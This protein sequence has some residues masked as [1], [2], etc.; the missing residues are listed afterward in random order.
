MLHFL[1]SDADSLTNEGV[2]ARSGLLHVLN[3]AWRMTVMY[4]GLQEA[5]SGRYPVVQAEHDTGL[6]LYD[7]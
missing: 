6:W 1:A 5:G 7:G 3:H 4:D 2:A